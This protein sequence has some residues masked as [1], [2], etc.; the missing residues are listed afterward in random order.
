MGKLFDRMRKNVKKKVHPHCAAI[1]PAASERPDAGVPVIAM[2]AN[3]FVEDRQRAR[4]AG[5]TEHLPKPLDQAVLVD[6]IVVAAQPEKLE[7]V[8]ALVSRAG[9]R[10][11]I[12]VVEGGASRAESVLLAALEAS[13][14]TEY[15]AIHDGARPLILPEQVDELIRLGQR[16]YAIAP[17]LPVTDTVKVA[18]MA[19]LVLSTP[20]RSTLF[21]VQT[22]QV[23]QANILKAA[24]QSALA[25]G[26]ALTD[27]C[28][29]VERLGK[30]V[31][32]TPGWR[33]NIKIT[34]PEDLAVAEAFLRRRGEAQ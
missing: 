6:E 2:T 21:A 30:E 14:D 4:E 23:F 26:A 11:P 31:Y 3:A 32:L 13:P 34:T 24:L 27:D 28:S 5:M 22:P 7:E 25:A 16:T 8:A 15:L 12:R 20:D 9:I 29:A 1:V 10:K 33:E 19:G 18:D 17:A